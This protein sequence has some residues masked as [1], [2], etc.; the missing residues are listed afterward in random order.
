VTFGPGARTAWHTDD[1]PGQ[2][3]IVTS[4]VARV[5]MRSLLRI[6][7]RFVDLVTCEAILFPVYLFTRFERRRA[8]AI[9]TDLQSRGEGSG[10]QSNNFNSSNQS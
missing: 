7:E 4:G 1:P 3:L 5:T 8:A 9:V 2:T 6:A 10:T